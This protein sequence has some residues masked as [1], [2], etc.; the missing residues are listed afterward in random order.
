MDKMIYK[1]K[2]A[3]EIAALHQQ[4]RAGQR[5]VEGGGEG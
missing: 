5:Q 4:L 1:E 2:L 3:G